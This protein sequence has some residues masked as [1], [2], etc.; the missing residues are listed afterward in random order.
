M[1]D[2]LVMLVFIIGLLT[3]GKFV[4]NLSTSVLIWLVVGIVVYMGLMYFNIL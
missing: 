2:I 3:V 4:L 1:I